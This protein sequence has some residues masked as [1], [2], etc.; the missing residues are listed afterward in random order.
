MARRMTVGILGG[1][2]DH[3]GQFRVLRPQGHEAG[4]AL[5]ARHGEIEQDQVDVAFAAQESVQV[6]HAVGLD[7][8]GLGHDGPDGL[9][10][11]AAEQRMIVGDHDGRGG[12]HA[13]LSRPAHEL[14]SLGPGERIR[15]AR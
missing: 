7:H 4:E 9:A 2:D 10:Q 6:V 11:S 15:I 8:A 5:Y 13:V 12:L 3:H 14:G 1:R